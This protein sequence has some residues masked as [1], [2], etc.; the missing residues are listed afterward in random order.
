L[1]TGSRLSRSTKSDFQSQLVAFFQ[2]DS[3]IPGGDPVKYL[4]KPFGQWFLAA[5]LTLS[6]NFLPASSQEKPTKWTPELMMTFKRVLAARISR[7]GNL[8]AYVV[9]TSIMEGEKSEFVPQ[10]WVVS[11][12]GKRNSQYTFGEKSCTDPAFSPDGQF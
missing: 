5:L 12:D 10:I 9:S 2:F 7:D 1:M 3:F 6:A 4:P 8:V 11:A